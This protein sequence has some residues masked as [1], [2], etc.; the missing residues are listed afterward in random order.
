MG[1]LWLL[2]MTI[3]CHTTQRT[4]AWPEGNNSSTSTSKPLFENNDINQTINAIQLHVKNSSEENMRE[5]R[6]TL[7][8]DNTIDSDLEKRDPK[9]KFSSWGGKRNHIPEEKRA[10]FSSW[11]GKRSYDFG[12]NEI[13]EDLD[14]EKRAKF[15]SWGGKRSDYDTEKRARF[16]SWAGKRDPNEISEEK[17]SKFNS[18]AGKRM[19]LGGD[20][21]AKF[22]SWAGKRARFNSWAGKRSDSTFYD[23]KRVPFNSW[24]GKR[25]YDEPE[26]E[27]EIADDKRA[28]FSSWAGKRSYFEPETNEDEFSDEK[29]AKFSSWAG[30]RAPDYVGIAWNSPDN[31]LRYYSNAGGEQGSENIM[32]LWQDLM[33]RKRARFS[34]WAGKRSD[35]TASD[36]ENLSGFIEP[37]TEEKRAKFSSWAGKRD[38]TDTNKVGSWEG[39]QGNESVGDTNNEREY[40]SMIVKRSA[41]SWNSPSVAYKR[42][43]IFSSWGGKRSDDSHSIQVRSLPMQRVLFNGVKDRSWG[44][45]LRPIRRGPDFYAWGGKRST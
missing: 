27:Y 31:K 28:K 39:N 33:S 26:K 21:R 37:E 1:V 36:N 9:Y 7:S 38:V 22:S 14:E 4:T 11:G 2:S 6:G 45:L 20:K 16:S 35:E 44:S 10:K 30:K 19:D 42:K 40:P 3:I 34:S 17:R 15:S 43:P 25:S 32:K 18:W 13:E 23:E 41:Y 29:R 12:S 8:N 5:K 24:A